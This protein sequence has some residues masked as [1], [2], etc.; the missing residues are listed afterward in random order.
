M[1]VV[2]KTLAVVDIFAL[3]KTQCGASVAKCARKDILRIAVL[4]YPVINASTA[5]ANK[6]PTFNT[7]LQRGAYSIYR[8]GLT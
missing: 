1:T 5:F 7:P 2:L 6:L 8:N 3:H 4:L